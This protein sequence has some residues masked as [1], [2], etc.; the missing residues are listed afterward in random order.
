[1]AKKARRSAGMFNR[2]WP[3]VMKIVARLEHRD[4]SKAELDLMQLEAMK[5]ELERKYPGLIELKKKY[6]GL[7]LKRTPD[8]VELILPKFVPNMPNIQAHGWRELRNKEWEEQSKWQ[9]IEA[10]KIELEKKYPG[11]KLRRT[12]DGWVVERSHPGYPPY[13]HRPHQG[14]MA[15]TPKRR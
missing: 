5:T 2:V 8:G 7:K 6:P 15:D 10:A 13:I 11:L 4:D 3:N 1:M 14:M 12:T 9:R